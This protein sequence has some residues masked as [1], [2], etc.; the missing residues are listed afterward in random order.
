MSTYTGID[1]RNHKRLR[2]NCTVT[3]RPE[4]PVDAH[5][6][7]RGKDMHARMLDISQGGMAIV[8]DYN[9]PVATTL[10]MRFTLLKVKKE[11]VTFSGPTEITGEVRS[12]VALREHAYRLGICIR[13]MRRIT[14]E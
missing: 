6:M 12:S 3:Y 4:E 11:I 5:F 13:D 7:L 14:V 10:S 1:R 9:I 8:S 2:M